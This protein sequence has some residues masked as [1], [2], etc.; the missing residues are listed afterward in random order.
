MSITLNQI[1]LE[2]TIDFGAIGM[3][4]ANIYVFTFYLN[5]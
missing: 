5:I 1:H 3:Q 4:T 2:I